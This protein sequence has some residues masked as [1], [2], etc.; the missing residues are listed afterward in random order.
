MVS[1]S[2]AGAKLRQIA[3][4]LDAGQVKEA[5]RLL[6]EV[7]LKD[8]RNLEAWELLWRAVYSVREEMICLNHIL[9]INP[10]NGPARRRMDDIR[11][12]GEASSTTGDL[13]HTAPFISEN[14]PVSKPPNPS[15]PQ[16][17]ARRKKKRG[18]NVLLF[19]F[20][21]LFPAVCA[22]I[23]GFALYRAGYIPA[24]FG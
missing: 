9:A 6:R 21:L 20:L 1:G 18:S 23:F 22:G 14:P 5:R 24:L 3:E 8:R 13:V 10:D 17:P 2:S 16:A 12:R 7:L 15:R 4:L 19:L 11:L